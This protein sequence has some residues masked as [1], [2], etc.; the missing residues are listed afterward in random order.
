MMPNPIQILLFGAG[1]RGADAYGQYALQHPQDV[2]FVAVAEPNRTRRERFAQAHQITAECQFTSWKE[3]LKA[4]KIADAVINAT[5]DDMHLA[6]ALAAL[7]AGYDLLLEK[8]IAPT[9]DGTVEIVKAAEA[10]DRL[11][12]ICHVLRYTDYFQK[13]KE[14]ITSGRL[15]QVIN[16]SHSENVASFHMAHSYV[17]GHWHN[18]D[19]SAPMILAKCCHDLDLLYWFLDEKPQKLSS[20]G[21]LRHFRIEN[22]PKGA[23]ERCTEGCPAAE[24]CPYYAPRIYLES[25]PIKDAVRRANNPLLKFVGHLS[26]ERPKLAKILAKVVPPV[27][28][29]TEYSG[30][31]RNTITE[32]PESDQA[33]LEALHFGPYGRCVYRCDNNVVDHQIVS[34]LFESGITASL[35]MQGHSH[36]EGRTLRV[37]GSHATLLGKF[38]YSQAW[39]ELHSHTQTPVERFRFSSEVDQTTG[40][41]G[42]DAGLMRCFVN[43]LRE[44]QSTLTSPR[45]ALESHLM[46]FAAE[47]A[48]LGKKMISMQEFRQNTGL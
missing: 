19:I 40:H 4:G 32:H 14:I 33:V 38:T 12:M 37:D 8:P 10:S 22:A 39:L 44:E 6:S 3:A 2:R 26:L 5:Q 31:P 24:T 47:E 16:I 13:V 1:N 21:D 18:T 35:T 17:R 9:L 46:A 15:G 29:L 7:D 36:V 11:L 34:L 23:P 30:W 28:T 48:R 42:G 45:D 20:F 43:A 27:R 41:G 25:A